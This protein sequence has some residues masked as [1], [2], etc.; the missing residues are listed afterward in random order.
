LDK[1]R[2]ML[3][4]LLVLSA[5][6]VALHAGSFLPM[7]GNEIGVLAFSMDK[8]FPFSYDDGADSSK[9]IIEL[10]T[11]DHERDKIIPMSRS[12]GYDYSGSRG[13][14][15]QQEVTQLNICSSNTAYCNNEVDNDF[16]VNPP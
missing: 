13:I 8:T 15:V 2:S 4:L 6:T 12:V 9:Q 14:S 7:H 1:F 16:N 3:S 10:M 5:L 11:Y